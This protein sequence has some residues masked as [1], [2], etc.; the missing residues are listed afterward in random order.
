MW[1]R[2]RRESI[3]GFLFG[4]SCG[5]LIVHFFA[6]PWK[7]SVKE[8]DER[9]ETLLS[10]G[11]KTELIK[12]GERP[13]KVAEELQ[14][15]KKS[16]F[17][18]IRTTQRNLLTRA[19]AINGSWLHK[20]PEGIGA[21]FLVRSGAPDKSSQKRARI[22]ILNLPNTSAGSSPPHRDLLGAFLHLSREV[23]DEYDWFM[24]VSDNA[25]VRTSKIAQFLRSLDPD[26]D[27]YLGQP[28]LGAP[29]HRA[30][31]QLNAGEVF[32]M[33]GPGMIVSKSVL[34][35]LDK[36]ISQ[37]L[38]DPSPSQHEAVELGRCMS[39][40]VGV[41]CAWAY[42]LEKLFFI[43]YSS[44]LFQSELSLS[45]IRL[46]KALSVYPVNNPTAMWNTHR[47][48]QKCEIQEYQGLVAKLQQEGTQNKKNE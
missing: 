3:I 9:K 16:L 15:S 44:K 8:N 26:G 2:G 45:N 37:C 41:Q 11:G 22:P 14:K 10:L 29:E 30:A 6:S 12:S 7:Y 36:S 13:L 32:C 38:R 28:G 31:L 23:S 48:Y 33:T 18:A 17:I 5:M 27:V 21:A 34:K 25:Y 43:D 19:K 42:E 46:L 24:V 39:R 47:F 4:M 1:C 40:R 20:L 35:R